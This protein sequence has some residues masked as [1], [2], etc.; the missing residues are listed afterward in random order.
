MRAGSCIG[1]WDGRNQW[2]WPLVNHPSAA[3]DGQAH[4][5][6][7]GAPDSDAPISPFYWTKGVVFLSGMKFLM[8]GVGPPPV[9]SGVFMDL[10]GPATDIQENA[11]RLILVFDTIR[12]SKK[13]GNPSVS[14]EWRWPKRVKVKR[15]LKYFTS[16]AKKRATTTTRFAKNRVAKN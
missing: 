9:V 10:S 6:N 14:W 8:P 1:K 13:T 16:F 3:R 4:L 5:S 11:L 15:N 2:K 12:G 7:R